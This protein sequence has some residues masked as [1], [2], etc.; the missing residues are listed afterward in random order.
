MDALLPPSRYYCHSTLTQLARNCFRFLARRLRNLY[1]YLR[2]L[3]V[4]F[5]N[6]NCVRIVT[7]FSLSLRTPE[8]RMRQ[9]G[10]H[11]FG[12]TRFRTTLPSGLDPNTPGL[13]PSVSSGLRSRTTCFA[14]SFNAPNKLK[15]SVDTAPSAVVKAGWIVPPAPWQ[16]PP[17]TNVYASATPTSFASFTQCLGC[18]MRLPR[19]ISVA[20]EWLTSRAD[21]IAVRLTFAR[22]GKTS[23]SYLL[24]SSQTGRLCGSQLFALA[25]CFLWVADLCARASGRMAAMRPDLAAWITRSLARPISQ[26]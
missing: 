8:D 21:A 7:S 2:K 25:R 24:L 20:Y 12:A 15:Q 6:G 10:L 11:L 17:K 18:G 16:P 22:S 9:V 13:Y 3:S 14:W 23:L 5:A 26:E 1:R 4:L 19:A